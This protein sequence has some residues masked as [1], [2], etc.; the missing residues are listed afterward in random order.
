MLFIFPFFDSWGS[1][2]STSF[3]LGVSRST[4]LATGRRLSHM[5]E[6]GVKVLRVVDAFRLSSCRRDLGN[7]YRNCPPDVVWSGSLQGYPDNICTLLVRSPYGRHRLRSLGP[8]TASFRSRKWLVRC[9]HSVVVPCR[10]YTPLPVLLPVS[11]LRLSG[12]TG[13][14]LCEFYRGVV[15]RLLT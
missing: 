5:A 6:S 10:P 9:I 11:G 3:L 4:P 7:F 12:L 2:A 13:V 15:F 14:I 1:S 8:G